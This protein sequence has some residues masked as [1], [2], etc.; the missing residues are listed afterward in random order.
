[1]IIINCIKWP[2]RPCS[3]SLFKYSLLNC[4]WANSVYRSCSWNC[5][6][7][8][9]Q[10][11]QLTDVPQVR[12]HHPDDIMRKNACRMTKTSPGLTFRPAAEMKPIRVSTCLCH[13]HIICIC[14]PSSPIARRLHSEHEPICQAAATEERMGEWQA[15]GP[16]P[17]DTLPWEKQHGPITGC[18]AYSRAHRTS[19]TSA[20]LCPPTPTDL[21][22]LPL[23]KGSEQDQPLHPGKVSRRQ[24]GRISLFD[25]ANRPDDRRILTREARRRNYF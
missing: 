23:N 5:W 3:Q 18:S 11:A 20:A 21:P 14:K 10:T 7:R 25:H 24:L 13:Y 6:L 4:P 16:A 8:L 2:F 15:R 19:N 12:H 9:H 22:D 1:M 17:P